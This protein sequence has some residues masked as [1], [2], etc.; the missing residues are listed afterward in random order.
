MPAWLG[1]GVRYMIGFRLASREGLY[2]QLFR[3][4]D[5]TVPAMEVNLTEARKTFETNF[6]SVICMCQ[7]FLPLLMKA[8]GT[9]VMIG[10]VA[11]VSQ[12]SSTDMPFSGHD[13]LP[14]CQDH[15]LRVRIGLQCLKS[16]AAFVQ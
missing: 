12:F 5:Y 8:K 2:S 13:S 3:N 1:A 10:S 14:L 6:F 15:T 7:A 9:I 16:R 11:G 4:T